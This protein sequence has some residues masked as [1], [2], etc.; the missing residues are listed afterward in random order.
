MYTPVLIAHSWLR[1]V[2]LLVGVLAVYSLVS[3]R[4]NRAH[5]DRWGLIFMI[6]LDL[7]LLLGILLYAWL[8]PF[9]G[10]AFKDF[11]AAMRNP[12]LRFFAVEHPTLMLGAVVLAHVGRITARKAA[13]PEARRMRLLL[14]FGLALVLMLLGIP[15]TGM[16]GGRDLFRL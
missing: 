8:S 4:D 14:C 1:W 13:S 2:A 11:G 5:S 9:M 7:Q 15:W 6:T 16:A 3:D 10:D 12:P